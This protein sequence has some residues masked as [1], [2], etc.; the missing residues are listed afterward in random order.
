MPPTCTICTHPE[1]DTIDLALVIGQPLIQLAAQY[2]VSEDAIQRHKQ[3]HLPE[4][5][6]K[7]QE[8]QNVAQADDLLS[9]V[10]ELQQRTLTILKNAEAR[11]ND[12]T[13]LSAIREARSNLELLAKLQGKIDAR[14]QVNILVN[15]SWVIVRNT[16]IAALSPYPEARAAVAAA[17]LELDHADRV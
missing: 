10:L 1:K 12:K 6:L 4:R 17:L 14:T 7:A 11:H 8:A 15:P 9:Q 16:V 3:N 5:L 2:R 13:A